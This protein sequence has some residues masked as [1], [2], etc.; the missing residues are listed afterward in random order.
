[1]IAV[2]LTAAGLSV[3]L[4]DRAQSQSQETMENQSQVDRVDILFLAQKLDPASRCR[5]PIGVI[6]DYPFDSYTIDF[7]KPFS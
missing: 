3:Y 4:A 6:M 2:V 1:M 5:C 7:A